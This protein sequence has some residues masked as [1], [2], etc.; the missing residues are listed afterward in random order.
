M[1]TITLSK[2]IEEDL[3]AFSAYAWVSEKGE[4]ELMSRLNHERTGTAMTL[5]AE[6]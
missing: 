1:K 2:A 5:Y 4:K 6:Y 3:F